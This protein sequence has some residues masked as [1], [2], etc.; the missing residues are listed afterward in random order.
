[1]ENNS[2]KT[3]TVVGIRFSPIGKSYFFDASKIEDIKLG[4][5]IVVQTS[6]GWQLGQ[7]VRIVED[8]KLRTKMRYKPVNRLATDADLKKKEF[9]D[10]KGLEALEFCRNISTHK[11][12][13][14]KIVSAE[15][16]F[17]ESSLTY[18]YSTENEKQINFKNTIKDIKNKYKIRKIDF[19]KI[20][21][22][23][24]AKYLGGMGA[25]GLEKR[26]CSQF[27][28]NFESI[29][30][31]MAKTQGISLTPSDITGMCNRLKCCLSYEYCNYVEALKGMPKKNKRVNTP[32][33]PGKV[34][35]LA[36][37]SK[38]V[39]VKLDDLGIREFN[40]AEVTPLQPNQQNEQKPALGKADQKNKP[41]SNSRKNFQNR[42]KRKTNTNKNSVNKNNVNN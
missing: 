22:R 33:G 35:D 29:S 13:G 21:P 16:S 8:E 1:M 25:C 41:R 12:N 2:S 32:M 38:T 20:G 7:V 31:R 28:G 6:R 26:C 36:P 10:S 17:D 15:F 14:V 27:L 9:L 30:I 18:L 19:H 4:D 3:P 23:D 37:L 11:N 42:R 34:R 24:V 5:Y 39:F 40:S